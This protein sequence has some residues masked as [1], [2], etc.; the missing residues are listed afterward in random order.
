MNPTDKRTG[1]ISNPRSGHNRDQFQALRHRVAASTVAHEIT[2]SAGDVPAALAR[3]AAAGC[4]VLGINGGDGTASAILGTLLEQDLFSEL[5]DIVILPGGTANM[6][7]GDVGMRGGLG[8]ALSRFCD[9]ADRDLWSRAQR[10]QRPLMRV[11]T[12]DGQVQHGMFLGAGAVISGTNYA[13]ENIHARGL[14][15]DFSLALGTLRTIWGV[16]RNE[17]GFSG[18]QSV[19]V[20]LDGGAA[21]SHDTLVLAISTL[22][23]LA[24]GMKPFWGHGPGALRMTLMRAGCSRF[25]PTFVRIA[26]GKPGRNAVPEQGYFSQNADE[27]QLELEGEINLDGEILAVTGV[28]SITATTPVSFLRP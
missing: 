10:Q 4:S 2:E 17:P 16:V 22:N 18:H 3:L 28:L 24:F 9:Y 11:V 13:H 19:R 23:R 14:R 20:T 1:L 27:I 8:A 26:M 7:A 21:E 6:N 25:A 12:P 5:P 15:D